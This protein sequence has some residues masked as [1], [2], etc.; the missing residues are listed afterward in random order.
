MKWTKRYNFWKMPYWTSSD[1]FAVHQCGNFPWLWVLYRPDKTYSLHR[2]AWIARRAASR[3][4][5]IL[6][7]R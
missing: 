6:G 3:E 4:V 2:F 5:K 1:G 7:S